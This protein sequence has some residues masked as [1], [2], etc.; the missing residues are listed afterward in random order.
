M[1]ADVAGTL[2]VKDE[3]GCPALDILLKIWSS[4]LEGCR[5]IRSV[6]RKYRNHFFFPFPT[7]VGGGSDSGLIWRTFVDN[8]ENLVAV[9]GVYTVHTAYGRYLRTFKEG[10]L[11]PDRTV[12]LQ[13]PRNPFDKY[14]SNHF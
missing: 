9:R 11:D 4:K 13:A 6:L 8:Q 2:M 3:Q 14:V 1:L 5:R 7:Q 12:R 10:R